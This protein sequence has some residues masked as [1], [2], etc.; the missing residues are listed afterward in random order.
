M[1]GGTDLVLRPTESTSPADCR[2]GTTEA[3]Q[4]RRRAVS[5]AS[6]GPAGL[7]QGADGVGVGRARVPARAIGIRGPRG[8]ASGYPP[9]G[10][11][12]LGR[13]R[14]AALGPVTVSKQSLM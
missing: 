14:G 3:S 9:R 2:V 6:A 13:L 11:A 10:A 7:G 5:G 1:C 4:P 8:A 12:R